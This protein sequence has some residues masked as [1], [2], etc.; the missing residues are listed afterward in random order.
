MD[1]LIEF[2]KKNGL[3]KTEMAE[4]IG[5]SLSLY[6]KVEYSDRYPSRLF[7]SKFKE[8]FP[9]YDMNIFFKELIHETCR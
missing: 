3:T 2:R 8:A 4:R 1:C 5:V 6:E 7:L 9:K